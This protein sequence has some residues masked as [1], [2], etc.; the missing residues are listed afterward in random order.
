L[1]SN[2]NEISRKDSNSSTIVAS[3]EKIVLPLERLNI[4]DFTENTVTSNGQKDPKDL[5]LK[6]YEEDSL[7]HSSSRLMIETDIMEDEV[8][9]VK[10]KILQLYRF[11]DAES[12]RLIQD[13]VEEIKSNDYS[14]GE[15]N[16]PLLYMR[17]VNK[18]LF[19]RFYH[20]ID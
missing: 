2:L 7:Y 6:I 8:L 13:R 3:T 14:F 1:D 16:R 4:A 15:N 19:E 10:E 18:W 12:N 17:V 5:T 20:V 9:R 11:T